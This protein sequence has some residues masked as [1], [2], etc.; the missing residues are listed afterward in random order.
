MSRYAA[1]REHDDRSNADHIIVLHDLTIATGKAKRFYPAEGT[2]AGITDV[3][4]AADDA[5]VFV[6]G[7]APPAHRGERASESLGQPLAR[8][9]TK[10]F[11]LGAE[12]Q[13]Q[14]R[15]SREVGG[16]EPTRSG[17]GGS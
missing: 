15:H 13:V 11:V 9:G 16:P 3:A 17:R 12:T 5:R 7:A 4:Y 6:T 10:R 8:L 14:D 2:T 1:L